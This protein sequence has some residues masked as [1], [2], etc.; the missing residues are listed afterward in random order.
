[1]WETE[2]ACPIAD[3]NIEGKNCSIKD[4]N[5]DYTFD[6]S[7]LRKSGDQDFYEVTAMGGYKI[8][9]K[10]FCLLNESSIFFKKVEGFFPLLDKVHSCC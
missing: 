9:V 2:A 10:G 3:T 1:M 5:S 7:P 4:R 8:R 6:L